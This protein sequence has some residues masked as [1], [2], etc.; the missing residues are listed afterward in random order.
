MSF[1]RV[2]S[3]PHVVHQFQS[4]LSRGRLAHAYVF[5][6]PEG[7]GKALFARELS[8]ALLCERGDED[9]CDVCKQC[10]AVDAGDNPD[11]LWVTPEYKVIT[12]GAIQELERLATRKKL[13]RRVFVIEEAEKMNQEASNCLLK[14]LEEPPPRVVILLVTTSLMRLPR[15]IVSRCQAVRFH[16]LET[17]VLKRLIAENFGVEGDGLKWLT[18]ASCGS[19]GWA[20]RLINEEAVTRRQRLLERLSSLSLEDNFSISQEVLDWCPYTEE[21]GLEGRR[22]RLRIWMYI[23]LEYYRDMLLCK[24]GAG[25]IGLFNDDAQDI[26]GA[27][28]SRLS[29]GVITNIMEEIQYSLD[30][31]QRNANINLLVENLFSR[32]AR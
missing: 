7:V 13:R 3:Q 21:G 1:K 28:A 10:Q 9:A 6:G 27:K 14:T 22:S 11:L 18:A 5:Y 26:I 25:E 16:P 8:R 17:D 12:I 24:V 15:T 32:I 29:V 2:L 19:M 31:L 4:A 20:T 23:M 30:G